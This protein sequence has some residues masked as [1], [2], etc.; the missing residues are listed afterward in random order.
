MDARE[1]AL[2]SAISDLNTGVYSSQR[3]AAK[4]YGIPRSTLSTR[5]NGVTNRRISHQHRQR[6]TPLQEDFLVDW[7]L[8]EDARGYPPPHARAREMANR[9][10]RMNG[11]AQPVGKLWVSHFI[12][13]Q[14]RVASVIGR[15]IDA[16]RVEASTSD[17]LR[18]FLEHYEQ[19]RERLG[20]QAENTYNMDETGIALGVCTNTR[21][22]AR[23]SKKKADVKS[24]ENREWVS[25][26]ECVSAIGRKLRCAV[27]FK[28]QSLQTTWFPAKS[29]PSWLYTT[30]ENGWTSNAIGL[31]WLQRIFL[32]ETAPADGQYRFLILDGHGSHIS[33]DF[34]L[35]CKQHK[36]YLLYLPAHSSHVLQPLD[37]A[38]FSVVKSSY[39]RQIQDLASLDDAAPVKK[40]RFITCYYQA[41]EEGFTERVIRAGWRAAG[42]C[43]FN[44]NHVLSSSQVSQQPATPP[45]PKR[46][47]S[48]IE[49]F[50]STPQG[51]RDIYLAQQDIQSHEN[52]GRKTR[53]LLQK[54]GKALASANTRAAGLEAEKRRLEAELEIALPQAPRK[55]VQVDPNQRF[56]EVED[57]MAAIHRSAATAAQRDRAIIERATERAAAATA[58][59]TLQSMCSQWQL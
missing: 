39:R 25:I 13:R 2:Q 51:P 38:P 10:L 14:P 31:E 9:I 4:A 29:V 32:P 34:L 57:I 56:A 48:P 7:I 47:R 43:P 16:Q 11:D 53:L 36:V 40:E 50:L 5:L 58:A 19:T 15:K 35:L 33:L 44:I 20:I 49:A 28:G 22:L 21:V 1:A 59:A 17:Q 27:I 6:L 41:R 23:A 46:P 55:R 52:L 37:L 26:I 30:S 45:R 42:L 12:K 18:A 3:A 54:A 24:P 8:E